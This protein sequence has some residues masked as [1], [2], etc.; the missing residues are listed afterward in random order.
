M[1]LDTIKQYAMEGISQVVDQYDLIKAELTKE[2]GIGEKGYA[3][4]GYAVN[5]LSSIASAA[6]GAS[7]AVYRSITETTGQV[8]WFLLLTYF[9]NILLT[10][11]TDPLCTLIR[12]LLPS[13]T[14]ESNE[15]FSRKL[16]DRLEA[17]VWRPIETCCLNTTLSLLA[18]YILGFD[19]VFL[20]AALSFIVSSL[21]ILQNSAY[22]FV[23]P[24]VIMEPLN[25]AWSDDAVLLTKAIVK[26][27]ILLLVHFLG[28][29]L[30][31]NAVMKNKETMSN[32]LLTDFSLALGYMAYGV[33]GMF[34][35]PLLTTLLD[36]VIV[37]L[38]A[39]SSSDDAGKKAVAGDAEVAAP[40]KKKK[41]PNKSKTVEG[42]QQQKQ[43]KNKHKNKHTNKH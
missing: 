11:K 1:N 3:A 18:L 7:Q 15:R 9:I 42:K 31:R 35:G 16:R 30:I 8:V 37:E 21:N 4:M 19:Y 23:L 33:K 5:H 6:T 10:S 34:I 20:G 22:L 39:R 2:G 13:R 32:E 14:K 38:S 28:Y 26:S 40:A 29:G 12:I 17:I 27:L 43:H 24:W 25:Y 36:L 41:Q